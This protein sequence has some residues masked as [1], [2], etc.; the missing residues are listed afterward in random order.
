LSDRKL[1]GYEALLRWQHPE[2]GLLLPTD[3]LGVAED[4]GAAEE[5][6]WKIYD[7][8]FEVA[9]ALLADGGFI[10]V[11]LSGR[12]F[13]SESLGADFLALLKRH[14]VAPSC[15]RIE[16]TERMLIDNPPAAKRMLENL[17]RDGLSVALDDFGTGYSS[18]SYLHQYPLQALKI[19]RSFVANLESDEAAGA[20][21]VVRA[22]Q[23]L[24]DTLGLQVIAEGIETESQRRTLLE[25]G[26]QYGQGFLLGRPQPASVWLERTAVVD[27]AEN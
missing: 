6:D 22:I 19:D 12:H 8:V 1:V 18:L 21:A 2:R 10:S 23:A 20:T 17:R 3:F 4:T 7:R 26:C 27:R 24:A 14:S 5:I 11:N 13:R 15:V 9:P 16:V 25:L